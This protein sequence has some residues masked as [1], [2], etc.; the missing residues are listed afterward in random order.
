MITNKTIIVAELSANHKSSL[1]IAKESII[2]AAKCGVDAVKIQTFN[3]E[4][5]T[6]NSK[7]DKFIV[8]EGLWKG[9]S[10]IDLYKEAYTP[11]EWFPEL[12]LLA[13]ENSIK[14]FSSPF[15]NEAVDYLNKFNPPYFKIA[16]P[17]IE[18]L[19]LIQHTAMT[20]K[21]IIISTGMA[22]DNDIE[23]AINACY[24]VNNKNITLLH[25][26]SGYPTPMNEMNVAQIIRLK[27]KF[28]CSVGLSDHSLN[29]YSSICAVALG[30]TM[31]EKHFT[32]IGKDESL[33]GTFSLNPN[34]LESLV[35]DIRSIENCYGSDKEII[36]QS[37]KKTIQ[38]KRSLYFVEDYVKGTPIRKEMIKSARPNLGISPQKLKDII[39]K[40]ILKT[41]SKNE[42][43]C[44]SDIENF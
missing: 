11:W 10:L 35:K 1:A 28:N 8:S 36:A 40:K 25:C 16:S 9:K 5:I 27:K 15:D 37:E 39:G 38:Y 17:E 34:Q 6:I 43:V 41:V 2:T 24:E 20:M 26:I 21:P 4:K 12:K 22:N 29:N 19:D 42:P 18:D 14:L 13:E 23:L 32:I 30:A 44:S 3:P 7:D 31:I 33:D